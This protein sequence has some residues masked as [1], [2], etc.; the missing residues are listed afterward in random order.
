MS[1]RTRLCA[2]LAALTTL[3]LLA[4]APRAHACGALPPGVSGTIPADGQKYPGNAA[5]V[6]QGQGISLTDASVTV[7]GQPATLKDVSKTF[8]SEVG[9]FGVT[10]EPTPAP[11]QQVVITGTFCASG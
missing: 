9:L 3:A 4:A 7:D 11:G 5:V 8:F 6:L 2:S 10:V 1:A